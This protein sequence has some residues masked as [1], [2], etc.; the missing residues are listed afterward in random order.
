L[1][2]CKQAAFRALANRKRIS[3]RPADGTE[4]NGVGLVASVEGGVG[5]RRSSGVNR[6]AAN[7]KFRK[8]E[9]VME[10]MRSFA[11]NGNSRPRYLRADAVS[12]EQNNGLL[13]GQTP[14]DQS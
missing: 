12:R 6:G 7:R 8:I 5:K 9:L 11:E 2:Q 3:F 13:H 14:I 1:A 10:L 4:K